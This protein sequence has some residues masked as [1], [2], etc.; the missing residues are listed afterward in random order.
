M[1]GKGIV[2]TL[3]DLH[4]TD[5]LTDEALFDLNTKFETA[6]AGDIIGLAVEHFTLTCA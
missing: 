3:L 5:D 2:V 6:S 1:A 4:S